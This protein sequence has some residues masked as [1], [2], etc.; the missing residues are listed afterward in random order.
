ME[1]SENRTKRILIIALAAKFV[2]VSIAVIFW[3]GVFSD[4]FGW[5][6][7]ED[8]IEESSSCS[9]GDMIEESSSPA[10]SK[11]SFTLVAGEAGEYG[12]LITYNKGTDFED[13]Q[14][15]YYVPAGNYKVINKRAVRDQIN[16][17]EDDV[18]ITAEGWEKPKEGGM[19]KS[20]GENQSTEIT[21]EVG[22][23]IEIMEPA[24][25][26]LIRQ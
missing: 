3:V 18:I 10:V 8:P 13:T 12:K 20:V 2:L 6:P 7:G 11:L 4:C 19:S 15:A 25:F 23:H 24:V 17:Y 21:V 16:V 1:N 22:Q 5:L 14:W 26:E 9:D